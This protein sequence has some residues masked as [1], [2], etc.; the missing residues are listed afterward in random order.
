MIKKAV[1]EKTIVG[2]FHQD[3]ESVLGFIQKKVT[4]LT[5]LN[6]LWHVSI[7]ADI[8]E[9]S[10]VANYRDGCLIIELDS[11]AWATRLRYILPEITPKLL[12]H[13][14]L[15][16]LSDIEWYIQ[17]HFYSAAIQRNKVSPVLSNASA[18]LLKNA[19]GNIKVKSLQEALLRVSENE[20]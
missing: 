4:Q 6:Q 14:D 10:R 5:K 13:P 9:H 1:P 8:A 12:I 3:P 18:Q 2:I 15:Q 17:P 16:D 7:A 20:K 19:A 11:A